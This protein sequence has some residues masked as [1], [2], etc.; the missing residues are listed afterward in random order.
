MSRE[1]VEGVE[2]WLAA[3]HRRDLDAL[4]KLADPEVVYRSYLASLGG[5]EEAYRGHVGLANFLRDLNDAWEWFHVETIETRDLGNTVFQLGSLRAR[6]RSSGLEVSEQ[7]AWL[8]HFREGTGPGRYLGVE[9]F[10]TANDALEAVGL[11]E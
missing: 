3:L 10:T 8:H 7:F 9:R 2:A 1:N 5:E 6:G 4:L 11:S